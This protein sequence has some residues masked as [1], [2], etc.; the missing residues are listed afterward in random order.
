MTTRIVFRAPDANES[1]LAMGRSGAE[2]LPNTKG[3]YLF[4]DGNDFIQVQGLNVNLPAVVGT[5]ASRTPSFCLL[6]PEEV[7]MVEAALNLQGYFK[8]SAV[9]E[10]IRRNPKYVS[11]FSTTWA[12]NGWL[13][14]IQ[15][16]TENP[17]RRLGRRLTKPLVRMAGLDNKYP[18]LMSELPEKE[19]LA[20]SVD[21]ENE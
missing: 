6:A 8:I 10:A 15:S 5:P 2:N 16:S 11:K 21:E 18:E 7:A 14:E 3:R 1:R 20:V 19:T 12:A 9:A 17:P 4:F 13:T